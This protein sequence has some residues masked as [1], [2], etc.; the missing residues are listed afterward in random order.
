V[1]AC[2]S[3]IDAGFGHLVKVTTGLL[4][5]QGTLGSNPL[6]GTLAPGELSCSPKPF[7]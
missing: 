2:L 5:H 4:S 1:P 6:G 3:V 7:T